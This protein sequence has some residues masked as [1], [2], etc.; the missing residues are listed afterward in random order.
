MG[1]PAGMAGRLT[2]R[3]DCTSGKTILRTIE[4]RPPLRVIRAFPIA[5]SGVLVHLHNLS[6]G[7]LSTDQLEL[8]V[9]A[10]VGTYV[11]LTTTGAT[12]VYRSRADSRSA[13]QRTTIHVAGDALL[14]YLPDPL[15][16][17]A[18]ARY[19][20]ETQITLEQGAGLFWWETLAPGREA[21]GELFAYVRLENRLEIVAVKCLIAMENYILQPGECPLTSPAR[22][23][24]Y[25]YLS[26]FYICRVGV[27]REAWLTLEQ[28]LSDLAS[29]LSHPG[30]ILWG[31][32]ALVESG[33]VVRCLSR[34]GSNVSPGLEQFWQSARLALYGV[35]GC[36][37]RKVY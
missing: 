14:E 6:G 22:L 10:G 1:Y 26:T 7:I 18:G 35:R 8:D 9:V 34:R 33:L 11:Q 15:I 12:R 20:Q 36:L 27:E 16:P 2:L 29:E 19:R 37:P 4:Q 24:A 32:S 13:Q 28:K 17:F 5:E 25:R 31:V 21:S 23:G 30:E 3:F